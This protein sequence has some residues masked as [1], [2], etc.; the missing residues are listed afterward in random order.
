[1]KPK[2]ATYLSSLG[3]P[4]RNWLFRNNLEVLHQ[5]STNLLGSNFLTKL[6]SASTVQ[7]NST[8]SS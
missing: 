7:Q 5:I 8:L 6:I 1:M 3:P 4:L 2:F